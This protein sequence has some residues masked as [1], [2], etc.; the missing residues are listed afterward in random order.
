MKSTSPSQFHLLLHHIPHCSSSLEDLSPFAAFHSCRHSP[1]SGHHHLS[2]GHSPCPQLPLNF[3][4]PFCTPQTECYVNSVLLIMSFPYIEPLKGVPA[5][6]MDTD[7]SKAINPL[8]PTLMASLIMCN[9]KLDAPAAWA[10][11]R[12]LAFHV[13]L[14]A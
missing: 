10:L 8:Y 3:L 11:Q 1:N 4:Y 2:P 14:P 12:S 6:R 13:I 5:P 9:L 7:L